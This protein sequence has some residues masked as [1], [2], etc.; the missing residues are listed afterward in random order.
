MMEKI[1]KVRRPGTAGQPA[2]KIA[3]LSTSVL[4]FSDQMMREE[5][6]IRNA[7]MHNIH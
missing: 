1:G 4:L 7:A 5:R 6:Q 2:T 3:Q